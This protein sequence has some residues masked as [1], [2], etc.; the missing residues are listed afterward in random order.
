MSSFSIEVPVEVFFNHEPAD[1]ATGHR[2]S[3]TVEFLE[4]PGF[5]PAEDEELWR[6]VTDAM[7]DKLLE[8]AKEQIKKEREREPENCEPFHVDSNYYT[9]PR[10]LRRQAD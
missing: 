1:P 3:I 4:V 5:S 6:A 9:R 7:S 2:E 8:F 10:F